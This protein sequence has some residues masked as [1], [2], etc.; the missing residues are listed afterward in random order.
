[1]L[2]F[3]ALY[4]YKKPAISYIRDGGPVWLSAVPLFLILPYPTIA[5]ARKYPLSAESIREL[6]EDT[7]RTLS[8][9]LTV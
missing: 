9:G 8:R 4:K 3:I 7:S 6:L 2:P 1:M 5:Q